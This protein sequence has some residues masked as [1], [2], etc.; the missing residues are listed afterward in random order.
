MPMVMVKTSNITKTQSKNNLI[1]KPIVREKILEK[2]T[3]SQA[4]I[5][6]VFF[7]V[8]YSIFFHGAKS[9]FNTRLTEKKKTQ[10]LT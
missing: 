5:S 1:I 2:I 6:K 7:S 8:A 4:T 10:K 3:S 9:D